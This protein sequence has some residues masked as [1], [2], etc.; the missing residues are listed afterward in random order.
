[1]RLTDDN[2]TVKL[3]VSAEHA[4]QRLAPLLAAAKTSAFGRGGETVVD[5]TVRVASELTPDQVGIP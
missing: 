4:E 2:Q 3:P 1:M 5:P